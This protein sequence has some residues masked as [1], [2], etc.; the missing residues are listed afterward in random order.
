MRSIEYAYPELGKLE[1]HTPI[2]KPLIM[3]WLSPSKE[4]SKHLLLELNTL[5]QDIDTAEISIIL[6]CPE[7]EINNSIIT[8]NLPAN[9]FEIANKKNEIIQKVKFNNSTSTDFSPVCI[10]VDTN[11]TI[12]LVHSGYE[13]GI[14]E[15]LLK[16]A[17][18]IK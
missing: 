17:K 7:E 8:F 18:A 14:S 1:N 3:C 10:V 2:T 11:N 9:W 13:V 4:P 6:I 5:K 12:R 16:T 15:K